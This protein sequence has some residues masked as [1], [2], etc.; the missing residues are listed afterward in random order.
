MIPPPEIVCTEVHQGFVVHEGANRIVVA[1]ELNDAILE[2]HYE[3][4][5]FLP[6]KMPQI[7]DLVETTTINRG[8]VPQV[9]DEEKPT[10]RQP[11]SGEIEF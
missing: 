3:R 8:Q 4:S 10:N 5:Q 7:G 11:I 2:Q 6:G 9:D 1:Y